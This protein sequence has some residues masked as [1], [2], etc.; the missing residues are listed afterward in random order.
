MMHKISKLLSRSFFQITK[1]SS[2]QVTKAL[3]RAAIIRLAGG[4]VEGKIVRGVEVGVVELNSPSQGVFENV[5]HIVDF[6]FDYK[7]QL[8]NIFA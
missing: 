7:L 8:W 4:R 3:A 1:S 2:F 5:I 6:N